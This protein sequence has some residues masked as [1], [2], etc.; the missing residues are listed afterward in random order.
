M[1]PLFIRS[2]AL[3]LTLTTASTWA[4][5]PK[6]HFQAPGFYRL[7]L[8]DFEVTAL[9]D[10]TLDLAPKQLLTN[11]S[12][13]LVSE[14]L[15]Q[16]FLD[17]EYPASVNAYLINTGE[18]LVLIDT[19][20]GSSGIF[21]PA[22][23]MVISN[24]KSAG[25]APEQV[26]EIYFTHLHPDHVGGLITDTGMAFPNA[27]IR[28]DK[29]EIDYWTSDEMASEAFAGHRP[30]FEFAKTSLAS[31]L[32]NGRVKPFQ[33]ETILLPG[34]KSVPAT[35][36]THGHTTYSITSEDKELLIW[37]DV[38]HVGAVQFSHPEVT[39]VFD[40]DSTQ[41]AKA[42]ESVFAEVAKQHTLVAAAHQPF[43][44]LG[45][46]REAGNGYEFVAFPYGGE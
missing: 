2:V 30:F 10:G 35:G 17:D 16:A 44:G 6:Q 40:T 33:G 7:A 22:L 39:I 36:H 46:L 11:V 26:D 42:R 9:N 14:K 19:G 34:I 27:I 41:A 28:A 12:Q 25:Y 21:S 31:Y 37:G 4:N 38:T 29:R 15:E 23:G 24:L 20:T 45:F 18:K 3:A 8:G 32:E 5:A 43:P 1:K 13:A